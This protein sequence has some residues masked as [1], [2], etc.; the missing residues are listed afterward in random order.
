VPFTRKGSNRNISRS[1]NWEDYRRGGTVR[2]GEGE[3]G[4]LVVIELKVR[5]PDHLL[6]PATAEMSSRKELADRNAFLAS[7]LRQEGLDVATENKET[8][9]ILLRLE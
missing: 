1:A 4:D 8:Q 3:G 6:H 5:P 2:R 7:V 9:D